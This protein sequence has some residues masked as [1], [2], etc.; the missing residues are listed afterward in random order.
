MKKEGMTK[1]ITVHPEEDTNVQISYQSIHP[2]V[3]KTFHQ[4]SQ[5]ST[6]WGYKNSMFPNSMSFQMTMSKPFVNVLKM[7]NRNVSFQS[8]SF[9]SWDKFGSNYNPRFYWICLYLHGP[10]RFGDSFSDCLLHVI[11]ISLKLNGQQLPSNHSI[12]I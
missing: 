8:K 9:L 2:I 1:V 3:V 10:S 4:I 5:M 12:D 11:T 7:E 6:C